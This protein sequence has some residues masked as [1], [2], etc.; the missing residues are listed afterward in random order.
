V[1]RVFKPGVITCHELATGREIYKE[2]FEEFNPAVSPFVTPEGRVYFASAG[3]TVVID[4]RADTP[5]QIGG[6]EL[7]GVASL[8]SPAVAHGRVYLRGKDYLYCVGK[9]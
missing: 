7:G 3:K 9:E 5:E 8:A 6:G 2:R 4:G 1:I